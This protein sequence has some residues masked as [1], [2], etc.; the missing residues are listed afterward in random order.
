VVAFLGETLGISVVGTNLLPAPAY[1]WYFK[2]T[3][4]PGE[5]N[6]VLFLANIQDAQAGSYYVVVGNPVST[7][8]S[9]PAT[10]TIDSSFTV[11]AQSGFDSSRE[12]W[13]ITEDAL[14][15][16]GGICDL[17]QAEPNGWRSSGGS[18]SSGKNS[19]PKDHF[20]EDRYRWWPPRIDRHLEV[21]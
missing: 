12:D 21:E 1:Q 19:R 10:V 8:A 16:V 7:I 14:G 11:L 6:D 20:L 2:G 5:T 4:L 17:T 13:V 15:V 18:N 9:Q 3:A